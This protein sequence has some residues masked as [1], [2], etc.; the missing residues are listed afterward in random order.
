MDMMRC[1]TT[2]KDYAQH[3]TDRNRIIANTFEAFFNMAITTTTNR[4]WSNSEKA[5]ATTAAT[6]LCRDRGGVQCIDART[7]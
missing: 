3:S 2:T 6:K 7:A 4:S 5:G 1:T